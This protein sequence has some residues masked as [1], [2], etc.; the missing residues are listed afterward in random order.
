MFRIRLILLSILFG[1]QLSAQ[2]EQPKQELG[3]DVL[4]LIMIGAGER[5]HRQKL[6][7]IYRRY[8]EKTNLRIKFN[9]N[10]KDIIGEN[11]NVRTFVNNDSPCPSG[12]IIFNQ[13][14]AGFNYEINAG[15]ETHRFL[16]GIP[17]YYGIDAKYSYNTASIIVFEENC[18][19]ENGTLVTEL[20]PVNNLANKY[21]TVGVI[22][23]LGM[24]TMLTENV[25]L[26]IEFGTEL[27]HHFGRIRYLNKDKNEETFQISDQ[28]FT[29][30]KLLNDIA[31]SY[32]F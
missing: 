4:P 31:I 10:K 12:N 9:V 29:L 25:F 3:I 1:L 14:V 6:D 23:F 18:T 20:L 7:L 15:L 24:K 19:I 13:Y 5:E 30:D 8:L 2:T 21:H 32:R 22:P 26:S 27:N 11:V 17:I 28:G 16:N